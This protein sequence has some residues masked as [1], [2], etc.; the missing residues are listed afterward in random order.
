MEITKELKILI[1][2]DNPN[3]RKLIGNILS[4]VGYKSLT[5]VENGKDAWDLIQKDTFDVLLTDWTMPE[6]NGNELLKKIRTSE[7]EFANM[8]VLMVTAANK[9][10]QI[11]EAVQS[12]VDGYIVKPFSLKTVVAKIEESYAARQN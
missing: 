1:A 4:N 3:I 10:E 5:M 8:P 2:E 11:V 12:K 6:M 7:K 9:K